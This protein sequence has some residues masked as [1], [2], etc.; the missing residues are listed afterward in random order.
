MLELLSPLKSSVFTNISYLKSDMIDYLD[1]PLPFIIGISE[2]IWNKIFMNKWNQISDDTVAFY[3][4]TSLLMT[5]MDLPAAP[6]PMTS[7]L[8]QTLEDI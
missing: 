6:E 1:T 7:I 8:T 2:S 4:E 5:K 3:V